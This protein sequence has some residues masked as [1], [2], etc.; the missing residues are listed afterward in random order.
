[1]SDLSPSSGA[2]SQDDLITLVVFSILE[3]VCLVVMAIAAIKLAL[4]FVRARSLMDVRGVVVRHQQRATHMRSAG[5]TGLRQVVLQV[6]IIQFT[7]PDGHTREVAHPIASDVP[8]PMGSPMTVSIDPRRPDHA[9]VASPLSRYLAS[10]IVLGAV[11]LI[12]IVLVAVE[13]SVLG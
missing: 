10:S 4:A 9:E 7:G 8:A 11:F 6:P 13:L 3:L 12:T 2:L 5:G 1:M